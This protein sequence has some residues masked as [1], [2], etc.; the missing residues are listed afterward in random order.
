MRYGYRCT[1]GSCPDSWRW[2]CPVPLAGRTS[3]AVLAPLGGFEPPTHGLESRRSVQT[4]LQGQVVT[5]MVAAQPD[6]STFDAST[7]PKKVQA[8]KKFSSR[9]GSHLV[10]WSPGALDDVATFGVLGFIQ[11]GLAKIRH[12]RLRDGGPLRS[13]VVSEFLWRRKRRSGVSA[14]AWLQ[15]AQLPVWLD[16]PRDTGRGRM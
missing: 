8:P 9:P 6:R 10:C 12:H 15:W 2:I 3:V 4:E 11:L 14:L 5:C 16:Q 13:R 7:S 1:Q